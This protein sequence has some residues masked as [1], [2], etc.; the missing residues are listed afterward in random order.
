MKSLGAVLVLAIACRRSPAVPTPS[1]VV[2][3]TAGTTS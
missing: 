2:T 3:I 1:G